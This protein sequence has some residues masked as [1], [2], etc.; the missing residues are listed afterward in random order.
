MKRKTVSRFE[1]LAENLIEGSFSRLFG[2]KMQPEEIAIRLARAMEDSNL[3]GQ[4]ANVYTVRLNPY[5]YEAIMAQIPEL[6]DQL[7]DYSLQLAKQ[8][9]MNLFVRPQLSITADSS[10][11]RRHIEVEAHYR[12]ENPALKTEIHPQSSS[13]GAVLAAIRAVDAFLIVEGRRHVPLDRPLITLGRRTDNDIILDSPRV[14]RNHAQIRWRFGRFILF[15]VSNRGNTQV[16]GRSVSEYVL[17]SGDVIALSDVLL[18]YA[19]EGE[20]TEGPLDDEAVKQTLIKPPG[21][22]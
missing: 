17:Q 10:I 12:P 11:G 1:K 9:N 19:E 18:I 2:A 14:S 6:G 21:S 15:D 13:D 5:D 7:A 8:A 20:R 16:N 22:S 4:V 3:S